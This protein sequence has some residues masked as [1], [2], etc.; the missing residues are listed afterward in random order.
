MANLICWASGMLQV[1]PA[2]D[3]PEGPVI[4]MSGLAPKLEVLMRTYGLHTTKFDAYYVPGCLDVPTE[5]R[6][7]ADVHHDRMSLVL[8]WSKRI[9]S[10]KQRDK[11]VLS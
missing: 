9:L 5:G 8:A 11:L 3:T 10:P 4:I 1:L 6:T 2:K 7:E